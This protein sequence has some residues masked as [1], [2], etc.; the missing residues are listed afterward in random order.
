MWFSHK[1]KGPGLRYKVAVSIK[2]RNIVWTNGHFPSGSYSDLTIF[3]LGLKQKLEPNK[4]IE[5]DLGYCGKPFCIRTPYDFL[6]K[7]DCNL[8]C[9][10]PEHVL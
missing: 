10:E 3:C 4:D 7:E 2:S 8:N 9:L 5:A 1:F 6:S